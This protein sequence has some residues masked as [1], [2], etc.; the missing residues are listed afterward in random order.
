MKNIVKIGPAGALASSL[1]A[2]SGGGHANRTYLPNLPAK[3]KS[4]DAVFVSSL[5]QVPGYY[6]QKSD[7]QSCSWFGFDG[8]GNYADSFN[9][10][11]NSL[12][13]KAFKAGDN[14]FVNLHVSNGTW[15]AQ[16]SGWRVMLTQL[17]GDE[18]LAAKG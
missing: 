2:C 9:K 17:C 5:P 7:G 3:V 4:A 14:A 15:E 8:N 10:A 1:A 18:V 6:L 13:Q 16:G 12:K 11:L